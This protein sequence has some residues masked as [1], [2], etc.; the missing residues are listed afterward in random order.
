MHPSH[1]ERHLAQNLRRDG[2][3][4]SIVFSSSVSAPGWYDW[5]RDKTCRDGD[6]D[7]QASDQ[8]VRP[9]R[10]V[11]EGGGD[12]QV[13]VDADGGEAED[14]ASAEEDVREDPDYARG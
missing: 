1:I 13:A 12:G 5:S 4:R 3:L 6:T 10:D 9:H 2:K 14:G 7:N 8:A 11:P